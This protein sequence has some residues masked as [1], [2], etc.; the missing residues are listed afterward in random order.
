MPCCYRLSIPLYKCY[1]NELSTWDIGDLGE[2]TH[3]LIPC[4]VRKPLPSRNESTGCFAP[5]DV[6]IG[7]ERKKKKKKNDLYQYLCHVVIGSLL[8]FT[9]VVGMNFPHEIRYI[10]NLGEP[11]HT[12][13]PCWMHQPLPSSR[14]QCTGCF[15]PTVSKMGIF[16]V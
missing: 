5:T 11:T 16:G 14:D 2:P 12:L 1:W 7:K 10:G 6:W 9:T 4:W 8:H 3:T 15:A 13:I